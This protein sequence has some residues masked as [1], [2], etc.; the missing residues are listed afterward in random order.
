M[1]VIF[2][3]SRKHPIIC[4]LYSYYYQLS[5]IIFH[6]IP[7]RFSLYSLHISSDIPQIFLKYSLHILKYPLISSNILKYSSSILKYH[8]T[9]SNILKYSSNISQI[10]LNIP[11][12][13]SDIPQIF[14]RYQV[15]ELLHCTLSR[16]PTVATTFPRSRNRHATA[17]AGAAGG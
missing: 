11:K 4:P 5:S 15:G 13:S 1:E 8:L 2:R 3:C 14:L 16:I 9:S 17:N 6:Y 10:P 12:Y 7:I